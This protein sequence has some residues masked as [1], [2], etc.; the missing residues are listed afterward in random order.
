MTNA[1]SLHFY[2]S[3]GVYTASVHLPDGSEFTALINRLPD[4][5][6]RVRCWS[7]GTFKDYDARTLHGVKAKAQ[8]AYDMAT[9]GLSA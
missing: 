3:R 5:T 8:G 1:G 6:Y 9:R 4:A 7:S 2:G